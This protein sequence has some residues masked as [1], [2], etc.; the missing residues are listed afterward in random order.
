MTLHSY[1]SYKIRTD[2]ENEVI[3]KIAEAACQA[4]GL[5][6]A[7]WSSALVLSNILH[8]LNIDT[9]QLK[10]RHHNEYPIIEL[11]AGTG[12]TGL[13]SAILWG[14]NSMLT[15]LPGIVPGL[16]LNIDMN[17][18]IIKANRANVSCGILDWNS[19]ET[20][21]LHNVDGPTTP[22]SVEAANGFPLILAADTMY[23]E[24]HPKLLSQAI[25]KCLR[26]SPSARAVVCYA[27]RVAYLDY[28]REFWETMEELGLV[29][30]QEGRQEMYLSDWDDEKLH[31]WSIWKWKNL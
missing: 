4:E 29:A 19:P 3:I 15:D 25:A 23:T 13:S 1:A 18:D 20:L 8:K 11:G 24:Y 27:M 21:H 30:E 26:K 5:H 6:L 28:I 10:T 17:A 2:D 12:L 16:Q 9:T 31:E 14:A 7:T 22:I